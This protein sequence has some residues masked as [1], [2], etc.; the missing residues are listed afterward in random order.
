MIAG[1][2]R[3]FAVAAML[4]AS[5]PA[6]AQIPGSELPGRERQRFETPQAP[7]AQPGGATITLPS[8]VAPE[9]ADKVKLFLRGV[10]IEGSTV[11][12]FEDLAALYQDLVGHEVTLAQVYEI[13]QRITARY[14]SDGYVISRAIVPPQ[15]L[16]PGGAIVRLQV[17]EG[18]VDKVEW[19][20]T[21]SQYR[22]FFTAYTAKIVASRPTN[23][24]TIERYLLL[25]GDLPG[26]KFKNSLKPSPTRPGAATLVVEVIQKPIDAIA[27]VD[28]RGSKARGPEQF[29]TSVTANNIFRMHEAFTLA[30]ASAFQPRELQYY[31]GGYRQVLT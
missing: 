8:T 17:V 25:A 13:A 3:I 26:L 18:Y 5:L 12:S 6:V 16:S 15:Q 9:G 19:P 27:R 7:R 24:R 29:F 1:W 28:N 4:V 14:G 2:G 11:Y 30:Y 20:A 22:D 21:L 31:Y 23:I 10:R